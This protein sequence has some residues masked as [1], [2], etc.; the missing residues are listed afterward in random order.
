MDVEIAVRVLYMLGE[1]MSVRSPV[2]LSKNEHS[3]VLCQ[4]QQFCYM[5]SSFLAIC[6][7]LDP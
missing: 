5:E 7:C 1:A 2:I 4:N 3:T 6:S